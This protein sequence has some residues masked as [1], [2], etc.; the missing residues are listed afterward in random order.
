MNLKQSEIKIIKLLISSPNYISSYD[1]SAATGINRR[2][3]RDEM[4]NVKKILKS[5]GYNL[6]S[7]TSKGYII[8]GKTSDS[9]QSLTNLIENAEKQKEYIIPTL[10]WE[11]QIYIERYLI[12]Q[13]D[14]IKIDDLAD[15]LLISRS[16]ISNDLKHAKKEL[17][18]FHLSFKQ[19][20]NYGICIVGSE[21]NKRNRLVDLIFEN[22]KKSKMFYDYL[23]SYFNDP[24]SLE[25]GIIQIIK[26]HCIEFTDFALCDFLI[27]LSI[28]LKR[29]LQGQ[30]ITEKIDSSLIENRQELVVAKEIA[31]F[32]EN[33]AH[34]KIPETEIN[35]IAID[36]IC[37]MSTNPINIIPSNITIQIVKEILDT[38]EKETLLNLKNEAFIFSLNAYI[39]NVLIRIAYA[40]KIRN[41]FYDK[42]KDAFLLAYTCAEIASSVI[43]KYTNQSLSRSELASSAILF[44]N[45]IYCNKTSKKRTLLVCGLGS[46][47]SD[48][49]ENQILKRFDNSIDIIKKTQYYQLNDE[50]LSQYELII[51][52]APIHKNL[53][54]P[55]INIS[56]ILGNDDL[57]KIDNYLSIYFEKIPLETIFHP[58]LFKSHIQLNS[59]NEIPSEFYKLIHDQY[60]RLKESLITNI[61]LEDFATI[62]FYNHGISIIK[63]NKPLNNHDIL[64]VLI[65]D[66]PINWNNNR[67]QIFILFSCLDT[68]NH[69]F[70]SITNTFSNLSNH[71][72]SIENIF[73]NPT[74]QTFLKTLKKYQ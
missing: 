35:I 10:P 53:Q 9:L 25:Y 31:Y 73:K 14:Y 34:C 38:I 59:I 60:T 6:I 11:R 15:I 26:N 57:D 18:K 40:E 1:I 32:I 66:N 7:K 42:L 64:S 43:F 55:H 5:L 17:D 68:N 22:L 36:L 71:I 2:L 72:S 65:L 50:N 13:N 23:N 39:E 30:I 4:I 52:T 27:C 24:D 3:V 61:L 45:A 28:S 48:I 21:T 33:K 49:I 47:A 51:S 62:T 12:E 41:P 44:H 54:I 70:N 46:V 16:T 8:D 58:R 20:P 37:K 63:L 29:I 69:I 56:Q 74:Y 67:V 19:K